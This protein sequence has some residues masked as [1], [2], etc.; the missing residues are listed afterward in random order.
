MVIKLTTEECPTLGN[1]FREQLQHRGR[2]DLTQAAVQLSGD[3]HIHR[4]LQR[5]AI[6]LCSVVLCIEE[7]YYVPETQPN[8]KFRLSIKRSTK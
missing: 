5:I 1:Q 6:A 3:L 8:Q 2:F 7:S 4:S